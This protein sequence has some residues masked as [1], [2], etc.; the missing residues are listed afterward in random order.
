MKY[1]RTLVTKPVNIYIL[2]FDYSFYSQKLD[3][4]I[5]TEVKNNNFSY[6]VNCTIKNR[7]NTFLEKM[8]G[9]LNSSDK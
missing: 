4:I 2:L 3:L 9:T 8:V 6:F 1:T 7:L 5:D